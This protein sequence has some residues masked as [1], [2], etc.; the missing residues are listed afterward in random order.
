[1]TA[2]I[3]SYS[4]VVEGREYVRKLDVASPRFGRPGDE[5][6]TEVLEVRDFFSTETLYT[7]GRHGVPDRQAR[8]N[9][10]KSRQSGD[11]MLARRAG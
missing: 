9:S 7:S 3:R 1:M 2:D 4:V 11:R 5:I 8:G 6:G 10:P